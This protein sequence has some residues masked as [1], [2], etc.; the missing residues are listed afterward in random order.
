M[1]AGP[2]APPERLLLQ[3]GA[4]AARLRLWAALLMLR[5]ISRS[6]ATA[7]LLRAAFAAGGLVSLALTLTLTLILTLTLLPTLKPSPSPSPSP[8]P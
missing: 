7:A 3:L 4:A 6:K 1:A 8:L 2:L 5:S